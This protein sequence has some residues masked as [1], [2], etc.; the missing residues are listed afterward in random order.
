MFSKTVSDP[1]L[2]RKISN[3][4]RKVDNSI[5]GANASKMLPISAVGSPVRLEYFLSANDD[6][7]YYG[8]SA[9]GTVCQMVNVELELCY[10]NI[11]IQEDLISRN[12]PIYIST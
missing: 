12:E 5:L 1:N 3:T 6:A 11:D 9:A 2:F 10:V 4:A 8:T 7:I